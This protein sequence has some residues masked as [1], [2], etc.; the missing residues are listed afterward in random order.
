RVVQPPR[1]GFGDARARA[2]IKLRVTVTRHNAHTLAHF[3][4]TARE[5]GVDHV[6]FKPFRHTAAFMGQSPG[7]LY[8]GR[9]DYEAA[10]RDCRE[11]WPEDGPT[12]EL[13]DGLPAGPAAWTKVIPRFGC[14]GGTTHASVLYDG[15][16]VA[17][18]A[19]LDDDDWTLHTHSFGEAWRAAPTLTRWRALPGNEECGGGCAKSPTCRGGCRARAL[20]MGGSIDAPD[21]WSHCEER[22]YPTVSADEDQTRKKTVSGR[23]GLRVIAE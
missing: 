18:D 17:C 22:R 15:R 14:V 23:R 21:P 12:L 20:G 19:V 5:L 3:A 1:R 13:D 8:L 9:R 2:R 4:T 11:A 6:T 10:I 7:A 16:V